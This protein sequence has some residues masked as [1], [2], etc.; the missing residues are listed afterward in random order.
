MFFKSKANYQDELIILIESVLSKIT[1]GSDMMW[2]SYDFPE[3]LRQEIEAYLSEMRKGDFSCLDN[4]NS[5]F[6][7]TSTFQEHSMQ[8]GWANQY[9]K[10]AT[11][12]DKLYR[13]L[14]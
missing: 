7:P 10:I 8:N 9:I 11:K 5:H 13:K 14:K 1:D 2:S 4:L 6:L 12:F 3:E